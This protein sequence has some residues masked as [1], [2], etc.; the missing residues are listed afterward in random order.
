MEPGI[1]AVMPRR[2]A[3]LLLSPVQA[4]VA[5]FRR[6]TLAPDETQAPRRRSARFRLRVVAALVARR[7][8]CSPQALPAM[9][10]PQAVGLPRRTVGPP[11]RRQITV[12][13]T[14]RR[15]ARAEEPG[16]GAAA[17]KAVTLADRDGSDGARPGKDCP[18]AGGAGHAPQTELAESEAVSG[19]RTRPPQAEGPAPSRPGTAARSGASPRPPARS[20]R[21]A[22]AWPIARR[23]SARC[24]RRSRRTR[25]GPRGTAARRRRSGRPPR[26]G[27]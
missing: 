9:P 8:C 26:C 21:S 10:R 2:R 5:E 27:A 3:A 7:R 17:A 15:R 18:R 13:T 12:A 4:N 16:A 14:L 1:A 6:Q 22:R 24:P 25:T 19:D 23:G 20:R 11:T